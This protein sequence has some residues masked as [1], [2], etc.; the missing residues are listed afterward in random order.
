MVSNSV[1][2]RTDQVILAGNLDKVA[3]AVAMAL[4]KRNVK[5]I[6]HLQYLS[7]VVDQR[8]ELC[9]NKLFGFFFGFY[10]CLMVSYLV[11]LELG[12]A[13]LHT[14]QVTLVVYRKY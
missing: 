3:R 14:A 13:C 8:F 5:V 6:N 10:N 12:R 2:S 9:K 1:A 7:V 4:C 11:Q